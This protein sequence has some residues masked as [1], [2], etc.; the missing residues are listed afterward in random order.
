MCVD[1]HGLEVAEELEGALAGEEVAVHHATDT[2]HG[3]A[4][5][6]DLGESIALALL[7]VLA[8]AKGVKLEVTRSALALQRLEKRDGAE[9]LE[10]RQPEEELA[11]GALL[12]EDVVR[13]SHLGAADE[14]A[15]AGVHG[16]VLEHGAGGGKHGNA[17]VLQLSLAEETD[18]SDTGQAQGVEADVTDHAGSERLVA[19]EEGHGLR[20]CLHGGAML[21]NGAAG[22]GASQGRGGREGG[23]GAGEGSDEDGA[24]QVEI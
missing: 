16:D 13:R 1:L 15:V 17:A 8:E 12:D 19:L 14:L 10:E 4:A 3:E 20:H 21:G 5:V 23:G 18:V 11:H 7:R 22:G 2:H 24:V 9:H 6:L